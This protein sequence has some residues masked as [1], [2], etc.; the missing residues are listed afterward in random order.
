M[1]PTP[2]VDDQ[3]LLTVTQIAHQHKTTAGSINSTLHVE[4]RNGVSILPRRPNG[5]I[6]TTRLVNRLLNEDE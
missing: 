1:R 3:L 2:D 5:P 4:Y 6:V